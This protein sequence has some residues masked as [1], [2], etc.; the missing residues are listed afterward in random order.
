MMIFIQQH[1][2][3]LFSIILQQT[4]ILFAHA[5]NS[6]SRH[7]SC[8]DNQF[9]FYN[10]VKQ[11][12][13]EWVNQNPDERCHLSDQNYNLV[14][15]R[16]R[17]S[18]N[19][20]SNMTRT[21][22]R[23]NKEK[24]K[25]GA[26]CNQNSECV[27]RIC[28]DGTCFAS[29]TCK[30]IKHE[31]GTPFDDAVIN[32]VFVGSGFHDLGEWRRQVARTFSGLNK[33][34]FLSFN[35][36]RYNAFYVDEL[37]E[38]HFC[39]FNC[40]GIPT[41]LCCNLKKARNLSDKCVPFGTHTQTIVIDNDDTYGGGGYVNQ[42]MATTSTHEHGPKVAV[43]ELAHSLF[44]LGDEYQSGRFTSKNSPNCDVAGCP[45]WKD[46]DEQMGGGLCIPGACE[47]GYYYTGETSLM[48]TL[49][50]PLG[51]VNTRFTCCTFLVLTGGTPSYCDQYDFGPGLLK[52]CKND[53]Q[54]YGGLELYHES[55]RTIEDDDENG[56]F[57]VVAKPATITVDLNNGSFDYLASS[58]MKEGDGISLV[59]R[60]QHYGDFPD[61]YTVCQERLGYTILHIT[62]E[63]DSGYQEELYFSATESIEMPPENPP[64]ENNG[65]SIVSQIQKNSTSI[66]LSPELLEIVVDAGNGIVLDCNVAYVKITIWTL[67]I[68]CFE[69]WIGKLFEKL[70]SVFQ[71]FK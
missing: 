40:E 7:H 39:N 32:L 36:P 38:Q 30:S 4:T 8:Q 37:E 2:L 53:Y 17:A 24:N 33:Y 26:T 21:H 6:F 55:L 3:L 12:S 27:S 47:G 63:F 71:F 46:L 49:H 57:V 1:Q 50:A 14:K 68:A 42:N 66:S 64:N 5:A 35:N 10:G 31:A 54:R 19:N 16:C 44:E 51:H 60:R 52:Y 29:E 11:H 41:L 56:K 20:C 65:T 69:R 9:Y 62:I 28:R 45:K 13:C 23:R 34:E 25:I 70:S 59:R 15:D 58:D 43:H 22:H 18:C 48:Q 67:L 61:L